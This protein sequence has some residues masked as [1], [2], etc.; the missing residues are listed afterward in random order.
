MYAQ[1]NSLYCAIDLTGYAKYATVI[2][3]QSVG[4]DHNTALLLAGFNVIA[5]FFSSL[6]PIWIIDRYG[7]TSFSESTIPAN[8]FSL[9]SAEGSSCSLLLVVNVLVWLF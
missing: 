1:S 4:M 6:T 3:E 9:D 8:Y 7:I 5:Y 2:F